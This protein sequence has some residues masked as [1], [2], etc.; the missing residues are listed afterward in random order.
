MIVM[1]LYDAIGNE[2]IA[3]RKVDYKGPYSAW[4]TKPAWSKR[5]VYIDFLPFDFYRTNSFNSKNYYFLIDNEWYT[6]NISSV[7]EATNLFTRTFENEDELLKLE[8]LNM[9][10]CI[11]KDCNLELTAAVIREF[12]RY[13]NM[14]DIN[15][16]MLQKFLDKP[17]LKNAIELIKKDKSSHIFFTHCRE[18]GYFHKF[19]DT[20]QNNYNLSAINELSTK[21]IERIF[22]HIIESNIDIRLEMDI[23]FYSKLLKRRKILSETDSMWTFALDSRIELYEYIMRKKVESLENESI[24]RLLVE[25]IENIYFSDKFQFLKQYFKDC[26]LD[27]LTKRFNYKDIIAKQISKKIEYVPVMITGYEDNK[28][29]LTEVG[30]I[31]SSGINGDI[32]LAQNIITSRA[33]PKYIEEIEQFVES[34]L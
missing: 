33:A 3:K 28:C 23:T 9:Y 25:V 18:N 11:L 13:F 7:N 19:T 8:A 32:P 6:I 12:G 10:G 15:G 5:K 24:S 17:N 21:Y 34:Y 26:A 14:D 20:T 30:K 2:Y 29:I 22:E 4:Y 16:D 27:Y 1:K 31:I